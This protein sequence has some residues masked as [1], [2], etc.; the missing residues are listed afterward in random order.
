MTIN[1]DSQT[2]HAAQASDETAGNTVDE[3]GT[4]EAAAREILR[5]LRDE[6]FDGDDKKFALA[7]GR[8]V[9]EVKGFIGGDETVDDDVVM[10]ARGIAVSRNI[11]LD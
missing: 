6:G 1:D 4:S 3:R 9:E 8:P 2:N 5:R 11:Q 7:L 10:K